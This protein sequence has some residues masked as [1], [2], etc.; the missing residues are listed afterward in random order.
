MPAHD[1]QERTQF[2]ARLATYTDAELREAEAN[3]EYSRNWNR[4]NNC[5]DHVLRLL[6]EDLEDIRAEIKRRT[7]DTRA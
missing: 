3:T 6:G 4:R 7:D 5:A 2:R 1:S